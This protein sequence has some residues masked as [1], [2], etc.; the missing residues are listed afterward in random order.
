MRPEN[1]DLYGSLTTAREAGISLRQLY[2]WINVLQVVT[3]Q[4]HLHGQRLF[5]RFTA[6]DVER[7]SRMKSLIDRGYT[8]RAAVH[9]VKRHGEVA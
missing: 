7:I 4:A 3:P 1:G 5:R 8:L 6:Q 9:L 2:Y